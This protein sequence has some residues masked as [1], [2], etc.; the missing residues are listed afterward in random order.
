MVGFSR[1][2]ANRRNFCVSLAAMV[3]ASKSLAQ[4]VSDSLS[5]PALMVRYPGRAVLLAGNV[6]DRRIVAVGERGVIVLSDDEGRTWRQAPSPVSVTLTAVSFA[7]ARHGM[8]VGHSGTV[9]TTSDAGENWQV[10]LDGRKVA[11]LVLDSA[12]TSDDPRVKKEAEQF[13][14]EGPD[15][16]FLDLVLFDARRAIIVGAYGLAFE[17]QDGGATWKSWMSRMDNPKSLHLYAIRRE[18]NDM[19]VAGEQGLVLLSTDGG[20]KFRRLTSPY[21]GS[22]FTAEILR[23]G[24]LLLA[25]LR[26]NIWRSDRGGA[27]WTQIPVSVPA[28]ITASAVRPDGTLLLGTQAGFVLEL[29]DGRLAP[30]NSSSLPPVNGLVVSK[31]LTLALTV[32]GAIPVSASPIQDASK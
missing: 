29:R 14:A 19:I 24:T 18:G 6:A 32:Q 31:N 16:P 10:R 21:I 28:S 1:F 9:L 30:I 23:D 20:T 13:V 12:R 26:G 2:A 3:A 8:A 25:G 15:K 27:G 11:Q 4:P 7:D 17:T 22:F 5:R